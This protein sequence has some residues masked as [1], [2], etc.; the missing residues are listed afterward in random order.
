MKTLIVKNRCHLYCEKY[1]KENKKVSGIKVRNAKGM[2]DGIKEDK[3]GNNV[4]SL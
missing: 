4:D 3:E 1:R 2:E